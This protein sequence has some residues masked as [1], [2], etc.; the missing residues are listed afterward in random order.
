MIE[1]RHISKSFN[2]VSVLKDISF[3][4]YDVEFVCI[5]GPSGCA[6][7]TALKMINRLIKPTSGSIFVDNKD[8]AQENEIALRRNLGY[9]IQQTGLFPHMTVKDN[10]EIILKL[11][12]DNVEAVLNKTKE[13][14]NMV[15]LD[16]DLYMNKYPGELSGFQQQ[17]VGV[18]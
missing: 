5:I 8:V 1:F 4:V 3:S 18:A 11:Q 13:V 10:V 15:G 2:D 16:P 14:L 12:N 17:R 7:T 6:K 9:V